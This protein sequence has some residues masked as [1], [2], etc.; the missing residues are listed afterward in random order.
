MD[1]LAPCSYAR[2]SW[3]KLRLFA[4]MCD[5]VKIWTLK[6]TPKYRKNSF[7]KR[8]SAFFFY[9]K[10]LKIMG[11]KHMTYHLFESWCWFTV[12]HLF[13]FS[14]SSS[15]SPTLPATTLTCVKWCSLTWSQ[16]CG[17]SLGASSCGSAPSSTSPLTTGR[18]PGVPRL[19]TGVVGGRVCGNGGGGKDRG[20]TLGVRV[21]MRDF[22]LPL[23]GL[24]QTTTMKKKTVAFLCRFRT[25][26]FK[27][28]SF[29]Y[30]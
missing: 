27:M 11:L 10:Y 13:L 6:K 28:L 22:S 15:S 18:P 16:S 7:S 8:N 1:R 21:G 30:S 23:F 4:W 14:L 20:K 29:F 2:V 25:S 3:C 24:K 19:R 17:P 12:S 9:S 5:A 26:A